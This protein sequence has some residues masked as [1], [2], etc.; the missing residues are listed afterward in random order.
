MFKWVRSALGTL[1]SMTIACRTLVSGFVALLFVTSANSQSAGSLCAA[2]PSS[3]PQ[4]AALAPVARDFAAGLSD[5]SE[6][7]RDLA[8]RKELLAGNVPLFMR[9]LQPVSI[10]GRL[11]G[12]GAVRLTLCVLADYL[13]VGSDEDFLRVP[14]GLDT[15][16]IVATAFGFV[17]P[18]R[19][20]VDLIYRQSSVRL[21]PQPLPAGDEMRSTRYY[22]LHNAMVQQQRVEVHAPLA[23]LSSGQKKDL[24]LSARLWDQPGRVAIYGW[25]RGADAPIQPLSTVHGARYADYSHGVRLVSNVVYVNGA[26]RSIFEL[27]GD[28]RFAALLSDEGPLRRAA[29]LFGAAVARSLGE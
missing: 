27:L 26:P 23:T 8:I 24:V 12:L 16:L 4:R 7:A 14:M 6:S 21:A 25:H 17:L 3:I 29:E 19:Q 18:T 9:S 28:E 13:S 1:N 5:L 2:S 11:P 15:A 10:D 20:I 22:Q